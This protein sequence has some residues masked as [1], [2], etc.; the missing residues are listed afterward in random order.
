MATF[1]SSFI[2]MVSGLR[3]YVATGQ[4]GLKFEYTSNSQANDG[5]WERL[6][7]QTTQLDERQQTRLANIATAR[8][9]FLALPDQM[10]A[11]LEGE[12]AREDL[13]L[14]RTEAVPVSRVMLQLLED[15]TGSQQQLLQSDIVD[16]SDSLSRARWQTIAG[17]LLALI[18]ATALAILLRNQI[19]GPIER[20][21]GVAD[22][23]R[24]GDL[25]AR[26]RVESRDEVGTLAE[27]FNRMAERLNQTLAELEERSRELQSRNSDLAEA[28]E[29]QTATSEVLKV[30]SSS[31]FWIR[32]CRRWSKQQPGSAEP[33]R[34]T[35]T[36]STA[37][38]P[39]QSP[40][41]TSPPK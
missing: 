41:T 1:Q 28:L 40:I 26:A 14:F 13:Y 36:G 24:S 30:I 18:A 7:N 38:W 3:G 34:G 9:Q 20:L 22:Q 5:A 15:L 37:R 27:T 29:Q 21:T 10:F 16:G 12:H 4:D 19:V 31:T 17:G 33:R 32:S 2:A 39:G 8:D 35:S 6:N 25:S 23:I 11:A